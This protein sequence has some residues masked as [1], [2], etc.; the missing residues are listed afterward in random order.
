M[1][2]LFFTTPAKQR[3]KR[4]RQQR[5]TTPSRTEVILTW[6]LL[7]VWLLLM[8]FGVV[9]HLNPRWLQEL[10][11]PGRRV[12]AAEASRFGD[13]ALRQ[14]Q[15]ALA[16]ANYGRS[17][18][19]LPDQ[20]GVQLS[21]AIAYR[22]AGNFADGERVLM[23][24]LQWEGS[25]RLKAAV[26]Y[27]LGELYEKQGKHDAALGCFEQASRHEVGDERIHRRLA[28]LYAAKGQYEQARVAC[29]R[30]LEILLDP[31]LEYNAMLRRSLDAYKDYPEHLQVIEQQLARGIGADELAR[32]DLEIIRHVQQNSPEV[33]AMYDH[34]GV[35][36]RL[37]DDID[38]AI[39]YFRKVLEIQPDN[40]TAKNRLQQLQQLQQGQP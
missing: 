40:V 14:G 29:Q 24:M 32:Y 15:Y 38:G 2:S 7:A 4:R 6:C 9:A 19:I 26:Y 20:P 12:E 36:C 13:N 33:A 1:F 11:Q 25:P 8:S 3:Q 31:G 5:D 21:I 39:G 37:V 30:A 16:I 34:L 35:F 23:D 17:L 18:E 27:N 22:D 28:S 10:S